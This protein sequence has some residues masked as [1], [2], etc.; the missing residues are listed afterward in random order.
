[1][2][3]L[4][5]RRFLC[6]AAR[7]AGLVPGL[8]SLPALAQQVVINEI[9]YDEDDPTVHSEF[10]ELHNPSISAPADLSGCYFSDGVS[11]K[12]PAGTV[13]PPGGFV[14]VCGDPAVI[15]SKFG[16]SGPAVFN[17]NAGVA[18]PVFGQLKSSGEIITLRSASGEKLDEVEYAQGFP[19]PTVGDPP[20]YSIELINPAL[21]NN[22]GGHWRRSDGTGGAEGK[23]PTPGRANSVLSS[24]SSPAIRQVEHIP[25][26]E[27]PPPEW[28]PSAKPVRVTA[29]ITDPNG[30]GAVSLAWQMVEPG[31]YIKLTDPRYA[32]PASWV[33]LPMTDNGTGGD[34]VAGDAVYTAVIP[35][36]T[37]THR[38][39]IRYR[40]T[41]SDDSGNEVRAPYGDDPQPNFAYYVYDA[42]PDWTGKA[43]AAAP[44]VTYPS[45]LLATVP[46]Y[47]FITRVE[48]HANAQ[49]VPVFKA[50]GAK[51]NPTAGKYTHSLYNWQGALCYDGHVYDHIRFRARGGVWRF[52]MGKNM[53]KFDFN[54]G[55]DFQAR[56][57]YGWKYAQK[58]KKL[59]FS[60]CIQ[61][62]SSGMRGEQGLFESVGFRLF[63][64]TGLP[65]EN[66][67]F[68]HF[69]IVEHPSETND[70]AS[71]YDDDFQGLYLGIEQM[72][73]QFL[74]EHGLPDGNL[75]KMENG[76]GELNHTGPAGPKNKSDLTAFLRYTST[77]AWWRANCDLPNYYNYRSIIDCI[78]HYDIGDGKNY[79]YY[80]NPLTTRWTALPWDLDLTWQD[81][82]YRADTGIAGLSPSS[83]STEPFFSRVF[84]PSQAGTGP[85]PA[86]RMEMRN[87]VREVQDL[88]FTKEQTGMLIDEMASVI[89]QPGQPSFVDAD[90]A[91]WDNNPIMTSSFVDAGQAGWNHYY[92]SAVND[93]VTPENESGKFA[94]MIVRMKNYITTRRNV[95]AARVL[96]S[97]EE[98]LIPATPVLTLADGGAGPVPVNALS[99]T[100]SAFAGQNGA[101]FAGLMWRIA[102]ATDPSVLGYNPY[103]RTQPRAY[104]IENAWQSEVLTTMPDLL[105]APAS[106]A[107]PGRNHRARVRHLD[108]TGRWSHWSVPVSF[109]AG[110]P[111]ITDYLKSLVISRIYYHPSF[112]TTQE[113]LTASDPEAY[114]WLELMNVGSVPL[115]LTPVRFTKGIDF[116]FAGSAVTTLDPGRRV[117]V[118]RSLAAFAARYGP[119]PLPNGALVAGE[120][121]AGDALGNAGEQLKLSYGAGIPIR[122]FEYDDKAPWPEEA[123]GGGH[124]LVLKNPASLPDPN[125]AA[126]WRASALPGGSP[127]AAEGTGGM[128]YTTWAAAYGNPPPADDTDGDGVSNFAEYALGSSPLSAASVPQILPGVSAADG[129]SRVTVSAVVRPDADAV[130]T[131]QASTD[132]Q[133]WSDA[134]LLFQKVSSVPRPDG[135]VLETWRSL[136]PLG[137]NVK[138]WFRFKVSGTPSL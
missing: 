110:E 80:R 105:T 102:E 114:E 127:G 56:D 24:N 27:G 43:K 106:A 75:Y 6:T 68:V 48:D 95:I 131:P 20:N 116:D 28:V 128:T 36:E 82:A 107:R 42:L 19:W 97:A 96:T 59:N 34:A 41:A 93:P 16:L 11:V 64:L 122:D 49:S 89:Y 55:H 7:L 118:V 38:R 135:T 92:L 12:F 33:T 120:W 112:P 124:A 29:K 84:G 1:M 115:D 45:S 66:T 18:P 121:Q 35:A 98:A 125:L 32:A 70:S 133:T 94:G 78:H 67:Q 23:G 26:M 85:I 54:K 123:D 47:H 73:G 46:A 30:I 108:S 62:G 81:N 50:D 44:A 99:F 22:L 87:R 126:S 119:L 117:L 86:L 57:N 21:D 65:A 13:V 77:E 60:A 79:F 113:S 53:W 111:D 31:D 129:T 5:L 40:I 4:S 71:Q 2:P 134:A 136:A 100:S 109:T 101:A 61:Q 104:E 8:L 91:M 74:D 137:G 39:L 9:H 76:T 69:R 10:I 72:D 90:R 52:A 130:I 14:V 37:Q 58:W 83:N 3:S 15:Q 103:D 132:L 17:W 51:Q 63:Q 138:L 25:M 88:L